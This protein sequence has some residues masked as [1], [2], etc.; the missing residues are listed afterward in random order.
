MADQRVWPG[1]DAFFEVGGA[2]TLAQSMGA[3]RVGGT[4]C[5]IGVLS[6]TDGEV[7]PIPLI[8]RNLRLQGI[9]TGSRETF[10][11]MNAALALHR[12]K[13]VIDRVYAFE[14]ARDALTLMDDAAHFGK[15]V[16]AV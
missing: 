3:T 4:V 8:V 9:R 1:A 15:I 10:E 5:L 6:S 7:N 2:G 11:A 13:P 12:L 16:I 14:D